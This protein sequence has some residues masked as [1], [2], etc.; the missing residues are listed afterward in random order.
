MYE[1][2]P[3]AVK[4]TDC[5]AQLLDCE[6]EIATCWQGIQSEQLFQHTVGITALLATV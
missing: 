5:P 2:A 1:L 3:D 4:V 6:A